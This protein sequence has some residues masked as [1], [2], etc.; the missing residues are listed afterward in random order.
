MNAGSGDRAAT[1]RG[2]RVIA[3]FFA[4]PLLSL[5]AGERHA[6]EVLLFHLPRQVNGYKSEMK[7]A[8][9]Q[10]AVAIAKC[11]RAANRGYKT[12]IKRTYFL[13][14]RRG[15]DTNNSWK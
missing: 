5:I 1:N 7:G 15:A 3:Y 12:A 6:S 11:N 8:F 14:S 9:L 13:L 2:E 10:G 4:G